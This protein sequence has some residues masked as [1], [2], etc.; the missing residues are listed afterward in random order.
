MQST[1][2]VF[3][4]KGKIEVCE[5]AMTPPGP[6]EVLCAARQSLISI[7]TELYC[8]RGIF[9]ADSNWAR[10]V[11]YP[12]RPGYS[13]AAQVVA[14]GEGVTGWKAGDRV[15]AWVTHRSHFKARPEELHRV[16][17]GVSDEEATWGILATTT[18]L[19]VRRAGHVL[20]ERVGVVGM[21]ILGQ[22]VV[23]YL[24]LSGA[25][26]IVAIDPVQSR[27]AVAQAHGATHG[28]ALNV[29]EARTAI[30]EITDG[31]RL[32][33][34]YDITGH[35]T[36]LAGCIPLVRRLGRVILLGDC[37]TPSEQHLSAG[38]V[39]NSLA[40][41]GIHGTMTPAHASDYNP[42]TRD[43]ITSLFFDYL[44]QGRMQVSH[45]ITHRY[46][47]LD[48]PQVYEQLTR[49]RSA[50]LGVLFDWTMK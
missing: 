29:H 6:G 18:Q 43:E 12:F 3:P 7:G 2:I 33:V 32:D 41:L 13:M 20:G 42:W 28:L 38:V 17:D 35:P 49:D 24:A 50:A 47:P 40:I 25:R 44:R 34:I 15:A 46:S 16:P 27:L 31:K 36:V 30:D 45:L 4:E 11:Q 19:G 5:E 9:D 48:A 21:G 26:Q 8:L 1:Y 14:V 10:W 39:S 23:Q 37:P 22:L